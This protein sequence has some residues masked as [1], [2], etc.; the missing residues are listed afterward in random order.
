MGKKFLFLSIVIIIQIFVIFFLCRWLLIMREEKNTLHEKLARMQNTVYTLTEIISNSVNE[1]EQN[2]P[3][4]P[5][6]LD[7]DNSENR[8]NNNFYPDA[9]PIKD[10][11]AISRE[12]SKQH[13]SIDFS[14]SLGTT[15]Y[16]VGAGVIL[17]C[18]FDNNLG[19]MVIIDH[20]NGYKSLYSHL[21]SY[22]VMKNQFVEKMQLIG[23]VGNTGNST[24][25]HLHF[26]ILYRN[27]PQ[28]PNTLIK[29]PK[30]KN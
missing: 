28:N 24:N 19:N 8:S 29:I 21:D 15:V 18:Y 5:N 25:P 1:D 7:L 26:Q 9:S 17:S 12:Y 10:N 30:F 6:E 16:A 20:L 2:F 22:I 23:F 11:Y 3:D 4:D 27:Q 14:S 13:E